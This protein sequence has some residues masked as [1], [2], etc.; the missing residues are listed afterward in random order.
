[1]QN[2]ICLLGMKD[3]Q[4]FMNIVN[5]IDGNIEI[6]NPKTGHRVSAR[7]TLGVILASTEW[8][9]ETWI[10]SQNDIYSEIEKFIVIG[11]NDGAYIH[12]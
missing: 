9:G 11:D 3:I 1:M 4:E 5:K 6:Y 2:K 8:G 7:S 12:E 10:D